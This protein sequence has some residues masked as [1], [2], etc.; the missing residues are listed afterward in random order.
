MIE[1]LHSLEILKDLWNAN[2][3]YGLL[4]FKQKGQGGEIQ[5][6]F[7]PRHAT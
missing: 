4:L 5:N 1:K 2:V 3:E 6:R 7:L